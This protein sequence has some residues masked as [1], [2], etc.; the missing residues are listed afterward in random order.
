MNL[1]PRSIAHKFLTFLWLSKGLSKS[2]AGGFLRDRGEFAVDI[3]KAIENG[4]AKKRNSTYFTAV[5]A[6][7]IMR[8]K[9]QVPA[10]VGWLHTVQGCNVV[11]SISLMDGATED[12]FSC[13]S[14]NPQ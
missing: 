12:D 5:L 14:R 10:V 4:Y 9:E 6:R 13:L 7:A 2:H 1:D 8:Q 3:L 11:W